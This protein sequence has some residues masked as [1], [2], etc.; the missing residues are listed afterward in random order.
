MSEQLSLGFFYNTT[1]LEGSELHKRRFQ[2]DSEARLVLAYF[3]MRP[4]EHKTPF[5][6]CEDLGYEDPLKVLNIRRAISDL[7]KEG[8][9]VKTD[10]M[11][12]GKRGTQNRTW[13]LI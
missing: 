9:L 1:H 13:R 12:V 7:T 6:V 5:E 11:K 3:R 2:A 4:G 10:Q 8:Y